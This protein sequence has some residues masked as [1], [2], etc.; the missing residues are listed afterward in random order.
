[1]LLKFGTFIVFQ[2]ADGPDQSIYEAIAVNGGALKDLYGDAEEEEKPKLY[3]QVVQR[4]SPLRSGSC[5]EGYGRFDQCR[6][7][8][9]T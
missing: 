2:G 5:E 4:T 7:M 3:T 9:F 6:A 1:M 8:N